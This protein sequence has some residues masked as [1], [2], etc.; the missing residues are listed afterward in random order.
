MR[1]VILFAGFFVLLQQ[2]QADCYTVVGFYGAQASGGFSYA[3]G[4]F[5]PF[6]VAGH[7]TDT[8]VTV[9]QLCE[10]FIYEGGGF[11]SVTLSGQTQ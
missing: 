8:Q 9:I 4:S 7:P 6:I 3:N 5:T 10:G 11:T 1:L 2:A